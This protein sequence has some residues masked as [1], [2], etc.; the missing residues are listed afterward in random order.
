MNGSTNLMSYDGT[1][2]R[3]IAPLAYQGKIGCQDVR[4]TRMFHKDPE[5]G[6]VSMDLTECIGWHCAHCDA[7]CSS[8]GHRCEAAKAMIE[9]AELLQS[10]NEAA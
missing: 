2:F 8:Q 4:C 5:T 3:L 7:P 9:A 1:E 10:E 6:K